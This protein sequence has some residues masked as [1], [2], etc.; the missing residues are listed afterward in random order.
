MNGPNRPPTFTVHHLATSRVHPIFKAQKEVADTCE[1]TTPLTSSHF[2]THQPVQPRPFSTTK[3][4]NTTSPSCLLLHAPT[5]TPQTP[6]ATHSSSA[7]PVRLSD[8]VTEPVRKPTGKL[9]NRPAT[10]SKSQQT[11]TRLIKPS[12]AT[13]T[14][15][16]P[17]CRLPRSARPQESLL[18][19]VP[20]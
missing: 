8:T 20:P 14:T 12:A 11:K 7:V 19:S 15:L 17:R 18:D 1:N 2:D 6:R 9:T 16:S 5:A 4:T 10:N 13:S 3:P